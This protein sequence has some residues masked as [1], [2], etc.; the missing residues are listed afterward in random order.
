MPKTLATVCTSN[1]VRL[2]ILTRHIES[3]EPNFLRKLKSQYGGIDS[4]H[5]NR[6]LER[7]RKHKEMDDED[8]P[9][10]VDEDNGDTIS[11]AE[12]SALLTRNNEPSHQ[13]TP[14]KTS[15]E[16]SK[17]ECPAEEADLASSTN[18]QNRQ[19]LAAIGSADKKR[20][21]KVIGDGSEKDD[22]QPEKA[23]PARDQKPRKKRK[24]VKL[25]F[26]DGGEEVA[27]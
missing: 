19:Q 11:R 21:A 13:A 20:R 15:D 27:V 9:T 23:I 16:R 10:Y 8:E 22:N 5:R 25:S 7:P 4:A 14:E 12:Y 17:N 24:K 18:S 26:D 3:N 6:P 1:C 2:V